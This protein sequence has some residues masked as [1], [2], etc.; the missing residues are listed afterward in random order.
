MK[1]LLLIDVKQRI[2][3]KSFVVPPVFRY[4]SS[5]SVLVFGPCSEIIE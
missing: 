2:E 1:K 3:K 4:S 5:A